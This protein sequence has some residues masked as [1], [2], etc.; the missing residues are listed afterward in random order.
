MRLCTNY[1]HT[2]RSH[3]HT[4]ATLSRTYIVSLYV[5]MGAHFKASF[6]I[7]TEVNYILCILHTFSIRSDSDCSQSHEVSTACYT[8]KMI[9][10]FYLQYYIVSLLP[11]HAYLQSFFLLIFFCI[12]NEW[13][14][15]GKGKQAREPLLLLHLQQ[16]QT[17]GHTHTHVCTMYALG[18]DF[19]LLLLPLLRCCCC[20][21]VLPLL[22]LTKLQRLRIFSMLCT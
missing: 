19:M 18:I 16:T 4:H 7:Y 9:N 6:N 8:V 20:C 13:V 17:H 21:S 22:V 3:S 1:W 2:H 15:E 14:A 11:G 12:I 5:I 10:F